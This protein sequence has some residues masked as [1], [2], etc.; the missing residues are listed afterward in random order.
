MRKT[1]LAAVAVISM[2]TGTAMAVDTMQGG[3]VGSPVMD[4][5]GNMIGSVTNV[6]L[7]DDSDMTVTGVV[8]M[9]QTGSYVVPPRKLTHAMGGGLTLNATPEEVA[10]MPVF[11]GDSAGEAKGEGGSGN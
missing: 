5:G 3:L 8:I 9:G 6:L 11:G 4:T 7:S 10:A 2:M 1:L